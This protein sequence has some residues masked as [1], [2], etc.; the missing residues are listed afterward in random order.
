M[1]PDETVFQPFITDYQKEQKKY[2][3]KRQ[4]EERRR[5]KLQKRRDFFS[6]PFTWI[7]LGVIIVG[8]ILFLIFK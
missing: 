8:L 4:I 2:E 3:E 6:N 1:F 5:Y 7:G